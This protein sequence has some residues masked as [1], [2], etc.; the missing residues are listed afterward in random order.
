MSFYLIDFGYLTFFT[1][2]STQYTD[3]IYLSWILEII[4]TI[5][6]QHVV[7]LFSFDTCDVVGSWLIFLLPSF[8]LDNL[9][10]E[11]CFSRNFC[12][13]ERSSSN[14]GEISECADRAG[15]KVLGLQVELNKVKIWT[16]C[17]IQ[18][19]FQVL[20]YFKLK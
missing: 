12:F 20:G 5:V 10:G 8:V 14:K 9:F 11:R 4:L 7:F 18:F 13:S 16:A 15:S 1:R 2:I 3:D 6:G 17:L 19:Q